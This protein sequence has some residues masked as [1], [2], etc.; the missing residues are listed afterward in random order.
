M[1]RSALVRMMTS[2][3]WLPVLVGGVA[4]QFTGCDQAARDTV[5]TGLQTSIIGLVSSFVTAFFQA[6]SNAGNG[7]TSQPVVQAV[8]DNLHNLLA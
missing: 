8:F 1:K 7:S 2:K 5:L 4:L 6:I 3:L